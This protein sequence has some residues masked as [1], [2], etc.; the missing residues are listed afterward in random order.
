MRGLIVAGGPVDLDQLRRELAAAPDLVIAADSGGKRLLEVGGCP[1]ILVGDLDSLPPESV[2]Q[3][4]AAGK[5]IRRYPAQKD[6][7]DLQLALD[8]ACQSGLTAVT[9]MGGVGGRRLD[10]TLANIGLLQYARAAGLD[11]KLIDVDRELQLAGAAPITLAARPGWAV[12]LLPLSTEVSGV[13]TYGLRYPLRD[14]T[15][16]LGATR[17]VHNQFTA[18]EA[19]VSAVTGIL[20][21][22]CFRED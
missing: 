4:A 17:G 5:I 12:S 19:A 22:V 8:L 18:A 11:A 3:I 21:V 1:E 13:T 10:H 14:E 20:L 7:T 15:L 9:I 6:Q 2:R 16:Y